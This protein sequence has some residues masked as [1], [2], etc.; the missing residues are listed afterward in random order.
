MSFAL[1][2]HGLLSDA[3]ISGNGGSLKKSHVSFTE[4]CVYIITYLALK[5]FYSD[6][7]F[8]CLF[9]C[10]QDVLAMPLPVVSEWR[11]SWVSTVVCLVVLIK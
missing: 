10:L 7:Y 1:G 8:V 3:A 6:I 5:R 9:V 2:T 4:Q 11:P